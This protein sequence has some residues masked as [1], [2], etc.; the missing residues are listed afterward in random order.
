MTKTVNTTTAQSAKIEAARAEAA[1]L[2]AERTKVTKAI[3][4]EEPKP[5]VADT[6]LFAEAMKRF[7]DAQ[8]YLL[9]AMK[10]PGW[11]RTICAL[12][13][14]AVVGCGVVY[15]AGHVLAWIVAGAL[16]YAAPVFIILAVYLLGVAL[17]I[18][19]GAKWSAR[20]AGAVLT[21]EADQ[22]AIEAYDSVKGF[23]QRFNP[24]AKVEVVKA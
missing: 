5:E 20:L 22:R 3:E 4:H 12:L 7:T 10:V 9:S 13:T 18:Y 2:K 1:K 24:F 6:D 15:A 19:Y 17:A 14:A 23:L 11:K 8:D 21:G 16:M